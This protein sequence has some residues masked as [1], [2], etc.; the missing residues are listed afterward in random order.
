MRKRVIGDVGADAKKVFLAS[1]YLT[2]H[3]Y[4]FNVNL[5]KDWL[6]GH[7]GN[8]LANN[9]PVVFINDNHASLG[10]FPFKWKN[11]QLIEEMNTSVT[12]YNP[13]D[14]TRLPDYIFV[15]GNQLKLD[16]HPFI[17]KCIVDNGTKIYSSKDNYCVLYK[18]N[19]RVNNCK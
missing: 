1:P 17:K 11:P 10:W 6:E 15:I 16:D 13:S 14:F 2:P 5:T 19:G 18:I 7:F 9:K 12:D 8:Y 4:V 3:S